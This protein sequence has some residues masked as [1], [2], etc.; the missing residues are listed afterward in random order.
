MSGLVLPEPGRADLSDRTL[1]LALFD[2]VRVGA[3][4][5][6][7]D[8]F[9]AEAVRQAVALE[10]YADHWSALARLTETILGKRIR[11]NQHKGGGS[12][13]GR[14]LSK[15]GK[16]TPTDRNRFALMA[17]ARDHLEP[18]YRQHAQAGSRYPRE[19]ATTEAKRWLREKTPTGDPGAIVVDPELDDWASKD[20]RAYLLTGK[21]QDRLAELP[22][23]SVDLIVTDP[24]YPKENLLLWLDL[25]EVAARILGPRGI[26]FAWSGQIDLPTVMA[27]LDEHLNYGWIF[28]LQMRAG[29][30]NSRIFGRHIIQSWKPVLAYTPGPWPSGEWGDDLLISPDAEK[31]AHRWQQ[32][33]DPAVRLIDRYCAPDGLVV[34]PFAGTGSFGVAARQTDR[35]FI[36]CE[37]D[38]RR[39]RQA[40]KRL[41]E[42]RNA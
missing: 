33:V 15:F 40:Q 21:F 12:G 24:P 18:I 5:G 39:F 35:R 42:A 31:G 7:P 13:S 10:A 19:A 8:E 27:Y 26:L 41:E 37:P 4:D 25:A 32:T 22:D 34:D 9:V 3:L 38:S 6:S 30:G 11:D 36:G 23:E 14:H 20:R 29:G 16:V 17:D 28:A 1:S 2:R